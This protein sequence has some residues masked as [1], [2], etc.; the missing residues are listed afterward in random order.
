[1][2]IQFSIIKK[3]SEIYVFIK[4][5]ELFWCDYYWSVAHPPAEAVAFFFFYSGILGGQTADL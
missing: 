3:G 5:L 4:I 2:G 1:M